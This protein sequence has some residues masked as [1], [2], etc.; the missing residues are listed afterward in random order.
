MTARRLLTSRDTAQNRRRD[1]EEYTRNLRQHAIED[2][3]SCTTV[4]SETVCAASNA[5]DAVILR[6]DRH[7]A[8]GHESADETI[9]AVR[10]DPATNSG[11][12]E[13]SSHRLT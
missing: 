7:R 9:E 10:Q 13:L 2:H 5:D 3:E 1:C 8:V 11:V 6:K 12:V 4:A